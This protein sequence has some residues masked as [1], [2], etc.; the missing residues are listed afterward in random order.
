MMI[1]SWYEATRTESLKA[2]PQ[3]M[4]AWVPP[5]TAARNANT[6]SLN[7]NV[8]VVAAD[9]AAAYCLWMRC[10]LGVSMSAKL[11]NKAAATPK[12]FA[13]PRSPHKKK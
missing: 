2:M 4:A 6:R 9:C 10:V 7:S 11:Q 5:K 13:A 8:D 3:S 1:A 12:P